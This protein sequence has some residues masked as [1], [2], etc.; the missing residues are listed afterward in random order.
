MLGL[1]C[2]VRSGAVPW[3]GSDSTLFGAEAQLSSEGAGRGRLHLSLPALAAWSCLAE[4][5]VF[6]LPPH[7]EHGPSRGARPCVTTAPGREPCLTLGLK[8]PS[9]GRRQCPQL[10]QV[11]V[12]SSLGRNLFSPGETKPTAVQLCVVLLPTSL[13][14]GLEGWTILWTGI[15]CVI[16]A[17]GLPLVLLCPGRG[18]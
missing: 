9:P 8:A 5:L 11:L 13:S 3:A 15:G 14:Y 2:G 12:V 1:R 7:C 6:L 18:W 16:A 4:Q 10:S 17:G